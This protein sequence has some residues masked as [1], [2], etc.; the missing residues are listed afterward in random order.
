MQSLPDPKGGDDDVP[1]G[2]I[3]E[4]L[5]VQYNKLVIRA[6]DLIVHTVVGEIEVGLKPH[7][8]GGGASVYVHG[9]YFAVQVS[10]PLILT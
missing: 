2:T 9:F 10:S 1:E 6:E 7:F 4:E 3:F 5:V 8:S